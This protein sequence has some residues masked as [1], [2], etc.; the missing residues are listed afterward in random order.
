MRTDSDHRGL[1]SESTEF[2]TYSVLSSD[3]KIVEAFSRLSNFVLPLALAVP[4]I[5]IDELAIGQSALTDQNPWLV[6]AVSF[7]HLY[8]V[9][10]LTKAIVLFIT[11]FLE[12]R[13]YRYWIDDEGISVLSG[14]WSRSHKTLPR[15]RIQ[16]VTITQ[17]YLQRQLEL[18]TLYASAA[19]AGI[20]VKHLSAERAEHTRQQIIQQL[21]ELP[22]LSADD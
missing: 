8:L 12:I 19:G 15:N 4:M 10:G 1:D 7:Y 14:V 6:V 13:R 18:T 11:G 16:N 3:A 9:Y 5:F 20:E 21:N 2:K 17:N 22:V